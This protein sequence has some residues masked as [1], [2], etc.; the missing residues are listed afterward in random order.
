MPHRNPATLRPL[1]ASGQ[2]LLGVDLGRKTIGLAVSDPTLT[3]ASPLRNLKRGKFSA[4][5]DALAR[6]C[7]ERNVGGMVFGL[8]VEMDGTEG[9]ACQQVREYAR[10]VEERVGVPV[11]FHD[12][13][14]STAA[15]DRVLV[16]QANMP[17]KRREAVEDKAAAA[18]ILQGTLDV[19]AQA[20]ADEGPLGSDS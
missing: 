9:R 11:A 17:R 4:D 18:Y 20:P 12:E 14:L 5:A 2:C 13:R 16:G 1:L 8:P 7:R 3:V 6:L 15:V 19:M 10:L